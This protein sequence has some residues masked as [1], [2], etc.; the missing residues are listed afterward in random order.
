MSKGIIDPNSREFYFYNKEYGFENNE[1][2][3]MTK[4]E[5]VPTNKRRLAFP[6]PDEVSRPNK[7]IHVKVKLVNG[8]IVVCDPQK[9]EER[10]IKE[11]VI[12]GIILL[13]WTIGLFIFGMITIFKFHKIELITY[14]FKLNAVLDDALIDDDSNSNNYFHETVEEALDEYYCDKKLNIYRSL[15]NE[16]KNQKGSLLMIFNEVDFL[17]LNKSSKKQKFY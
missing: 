7:L 6:N 14:A 8:N 10:E 13:F 17:G 12:I 11:S 3:Y 2:F 9:K 4:L 16:V 5:G 15:S 1:K